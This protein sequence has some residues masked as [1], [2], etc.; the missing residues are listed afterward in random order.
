MDQYSITIQVPQN[1]NWIRFFWFA[2]RDVKHPLAIH[3]PKASLY[4]H[5]KIVFDKESLEM[6]EESRIVFYIEQELAYCLRFA[7]CVLGRFQ[8]TS[9]ESF[10]P[11]P[12]EYHRLTTVDTNLMNALIKHARYM[13]SMKTETEINFFN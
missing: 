8:I 9:H 12:Y 13:K 11:A 6:L 5:M 3:I 2:Q 7:G 4:R 1:K 10:R